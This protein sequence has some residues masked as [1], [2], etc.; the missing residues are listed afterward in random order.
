M[1]KMQANSFMR[2]MARGMKGNVL[3]LR[4]PAGWARFTPRSNFSGQTVTEQGALQQSAV[5]GCCHLISKTLATLP[6]ELSRET[7]KGKVQALDHGLYRILKSKPNSNMTAVIFWYIV[8][9]AMLMWGAAYVEKVRTGR[10]ITSL[11]FL[12]PQAVTWDRRDGVTKWKYNDPDTRTVREISNDEMWF[13]PAY[14]LDGITPI[15]PIRF[16]ANVIGASIAADRAGADTFTNGM[17]SPGVVTMGGGKFMTETQR[18]TIRKHVKTVGEQG[19][20]YVLEDGTGVHQLQMTP[21][22]S[23]LLATRGYGVEEICRWYG[24]PPSMIGHGDKTSNW[25]TGL[26]QQKQGLIDFNLR[27][28][29][30]LIENSTNEF[31]LDPLE[32]LTLSAEFN[33]TALLR[34]D[35]AARATYYGIMTDKGIMTRDQIRKLENYPEMGGNAGKLTVQSAMILLDSLGTTAPG[36]AQTAADAVKSWLNLESQS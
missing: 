14:T 28:W 26:E 34:G 32:R 35:S 9:M 18:D 24:V 5:W 10:T 25:G 7:P 13:I 20:V 23:E 30:R 27:H 15:S 2:A 4:D 16:G 22:D 8:I 19:G 29:A 3:T 11:R 17:K 6:Y 31:L 21:Q 36:A 1:I 12:W 33:L